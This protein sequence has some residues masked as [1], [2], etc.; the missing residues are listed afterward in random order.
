VLNYR[1]LDLYAHELNDGPYLLLLPKQSTLSNAPALVG[2]FEAL[3]TPDIKDVAQK[4]RQSL[5]EALADRGTL[6]ASLDPT[7]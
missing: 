7:Q 6:S 5:A 2:P 1:A 4:G 3:G